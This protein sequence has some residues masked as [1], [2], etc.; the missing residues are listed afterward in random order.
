[1]YHTFK[2]VKDKYRTNDSSDLFQQLATNSPLLSVPH[3]ITTTM[4]HTIVLL[5]SRLNECLACFNPWL[6]VPPQS[7]DKRT[8]WLQALSLSLSYAIIEPIAVLAIQTSVTPP[9]VL[10]LCLPPL[11]A[12]VAFIS[13]AL[14]DTEFPENLASTKDKEEPINPNQRS[15]TKSITALLPSVLSTAVINAAFL[16]FS[17]S[18]YA[19]RIQ[20]RYH[21]THILGP[22]AIVINLVCRYS[23][24]EIYKQTGRPVALRELCRSSVYGPAVSC[25]VVLFSARLGVRMMVGVGPFLA[26]QRLG[27]DEADGMYPEP[28]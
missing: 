20:Q 7:L 22:F 26:F 8:S 5:L 3:T 16:L 9:W 23:D 27:F 10:A 28:V 18:L 2:Y 15:K 14:R 17:Q 11:G 21:I 12:T 25:L 24:Y 4:L 19:S 1:M 6:F 13:L